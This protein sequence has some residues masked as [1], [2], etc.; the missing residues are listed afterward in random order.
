MSNTAPSRA[1]P[2]VVFLLADGAH[3][4]KPHSPTH[5]WYFSKLK[6][7]PNEVINKWSFSYPHPGV[8]VHYGE[9]P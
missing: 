9:I 5:P 4:K 1:D 3:H 6:K 7:F 2:V 8:E